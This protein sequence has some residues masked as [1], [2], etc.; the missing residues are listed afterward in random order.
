MSHFPVVTRMLATLALALAATAVP[1][2]TSANGPYYAVPAWDQTMPTATRSLVLANF[3]GDAVLDRETGLVWARAPLSNA[4]TRLNAAEFC[5]VQATGR[6]GGWRLPTIAELGSLFDP[7]AGSAPFL[8]AGHPFTGFDPVAAEFWTTSRVTVTVPGFT[9]IHL[10][11]GYAGSS[12]AS[13]VV[14]DATRAASYPY[15]R[16]P[17]V[18]FSN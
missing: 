17:G 6:C 14:A 2:Q 8:P 13:A 16:G 7:S 10:L 12:Y 1:A 15:L 5:R 3:N 4:F 18:T 11:A 9:A